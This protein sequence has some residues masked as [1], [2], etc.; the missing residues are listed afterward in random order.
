MKKIMVAMA[1]LLLTVTTTAM[2][3]GFEDAEKVCGKLLYSNDQTN[4]L[5][6]VNS[7]DYFESGAVSACGKLLYSN[8]TL[9]CLEAVKDKRYTETAVKTCRDKLYSNDLI[10]CFKV[11]GRKSVKEDKDLGD[12]DFVRASL[13]KALQHIRRGDGEK[14][15]AV[16]EGVLESLE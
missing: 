16:L 5:K 10:E 7:A 14:A 8:D 6:I 11:T 4:C 1:L 9:K 3:D 12:K 15:E 2:A 13:K